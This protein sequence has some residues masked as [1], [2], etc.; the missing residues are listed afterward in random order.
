MAESIIKKDIVDIELNSGA[1]H[2]SFL[3]HSIGMT[4]SG[5]NAFGVRVLRDGN[6]VDLS[7]VTA[8]GFFRD[9]QGNNIAITSGNLIRGNEAYVIL[10]Q[11]CY[12]YEGQFTLAIKLIGGDVT[13]TMR[14]V[15]G[16]VDNTN[17]GGAVAPTENVPTYQEILAVY[18]DMLEALEN[19]GEYTAMKK[20][21][22]TRSKIIPNVL[23]RQIE[24]RNLEIEAADLEQGSV[25]GETGGD[26]ETTTRVRSYYIHFENAYRFEYKIASGYEINIMEY[27]DGYNI[28]YVTPWHD[29]DGWYYL[30]NWDSGSLR[31]IIKK[32]SGDDITAAESAA[33]IEYLRFTNVDNF[34]LQIIRQNGLLKKQVAQFAAGAFA[35]SNYRASTQLYEYEDC[36]VLAKQALP[37]SIVVGVEVFDKD[38]N[39]LRTYNNGYYRGILLRKADYP[40]GK[41][42]RIFIARYQDGET[43]F[44]DAEVQAANNNIY[45]LKCE[46]DTLEELNADEMCLQ[47]LIGTENGLTFTTHADTRGFIM[48]IVKNEGQ[49]LTM[50]N[51]AY[52][53]YLKWFDSGFSFVKDSDWSERVQ[54]ATSENYPYFVVVFGKTDGSDFTNGDAETILQYFHVN[55]SDLIAHASLSGEDGSITVGNAARCATYR[56]RWIDDAYIKIK[57]IGMDVGI[58]AYDENKVM[59]KDTNWMTYSSESGRTDKAIRL[60]NC[61]V[62]FYIA[63]QGRTAEFSA[64]D[65][66]ALRQKY[67][68]GEFIE[69]VDAINPHSFG[70][71]TEN[72]N[73]LYYD[74]ETKNTVASI[75]ENANDDSVIFAMITDLHDNDWDHYAETLGYQLAAL[76]NLKEKARLDFVI[77]GGDLTDGAYSEKS[78]LLDKMTDHRRHFSR[79]GVPSLFVRGNH[80]DN[81]YYS[82]QASN[83]ISGPEFYSRM[84]MNEAGNHTPAGKAYYYHDFEEINLRVICLDFIDYPWVVEDGQ[85]VNYAVGY[86]GVWRGYSDAQIAWLA[87]TALNTNKRIVVTGHYSTHTNLMSSWERGVEHNWDEVNK[88]MIAYQSRGSYTFGGQTYDYSGKTGKILAQVT[89]HSHSFGAFKDNGIVWSTTGSPSTDVTHRTYDDTPYET[90]GSRAYGDIT[91]AHFNVFVCD[92]GNVHIIS[93]GQMGDLD[94]TI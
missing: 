60:Q 25:D 63:K 83:C 72:G 54:D 7:G 70:Y 8:E 76:K 46:G 55:E 28:T 69:I 68:N 71:Q 91:E 2:R 78:A 52:K 21:L 26:I 65:A 19:M 38:L 41:Y 44:T 33:A 59:I 85:L 50:D 89:G 79:I 81:S 86:E 37:D 35:Q 18:D 84:I 62:R 56:Y 75:C 36:F 77:C 94:F 45:V 61:Y 15:D 73:P 48:R 67:V 80:D 20:A 30:E 58:D 57:N 6:Y 39:V 92:S 74:Q 32:T 16:M 12:N 88:A 51:T 9:P 31:I 29:G 27:D 5:A 17:T 64:S 47:H 49:I 66:K 11:A 4:D 43:A 14:I 90:M 53:M 40:T 1:I 23:F 3:N 87:G 10:P 34:D 13:G 22:G 24:K 82:L 42:F 93:F